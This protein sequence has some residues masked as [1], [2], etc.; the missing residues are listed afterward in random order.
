[1]GLEILVDGKYFDDLSSASAY[2]DFLKAVEA[3]AKEFPVLKKF[4]DDG[5][6]DRKGDNFK[7]IKEELTQFK[8]KRFKRI[9]VV[10]AKAF[11]KAK[12]EVSV[13]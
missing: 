1:M 7:E 10:L 3:K 4:T 13:V 12:K 9:P 5:G 6:L 8:D 2:W 11:G